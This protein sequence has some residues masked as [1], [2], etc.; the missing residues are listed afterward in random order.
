MT[1]DATPD[2]DTAYPWRRL[3]VCLKFFCLTML[4]LF[5]GFFAWQWMTG[6]ELTWGANVPLDVLKGKP[7]L[8]AQGPAKGGDL[9]QHYA[10]GQMWQKG[11]MLDLYSGERLGA[12]LAQMHRDL[13]IDTAGNFG[14]ANYVYSPLVAW[15]SSKGVGY[16]WGSWMTFSTAL[17]LLL[18][19][20]LTGMVL[21]IF[22]PPEGREDG[23]VYALSFPSLYFS[24]TPFQNSPLTLFILVVAAWMLKRGWRFSAGIALTF[25]F[26][27]PQF[28]PWLALF[29]LIVGNGRTFLGIILGTA[30][31]QVITLAVGGV[32]GMLAWIS[33][34]RAMTSGKQFVFRGLNQ[35]WSGC[36]GEFFWL[37]PHLGSVIGTV[38]GLGIFLW[39]AW[40]IRTKWNVAQRLGDDPLFIG[41]AAW[42]VCSTY[43]GYYDALVMMPCALLLLCR[44]PSG[45]SLGEM[46]MAI[47]LWL[48]SLGTIAGVSA[49]INLTAP[50]LTVW[51]MI[52]CRM[53][54]ASQT[55][56]SG[57]NFAP[58]LS[59]KAPTP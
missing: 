22:L 7:L 43:V 27:K 15:L 11:L 56:A 33:I 18:Y 54:Q 3:H 59:T 49:G 42:V 23:L 41:A 35:S 55:N 13:A 37:P 14:Q 19:L 12:W 5:A 52:A 16:P 38:I 25:V 30:F 32:Q 57:A 34:M 46:T 36:W 6:T 50:L 28:M 44:R 1:A 58:S 10:A 2:A 45:P 53:I 39:F 40:Q 4:F 47:F 21:R 31:W 51:L 29:F 20:A 8:H 26:Y 24:L 48:I 17:S 9:V